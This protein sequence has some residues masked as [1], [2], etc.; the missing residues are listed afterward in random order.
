MK[1]HLNNLVRGKGKKSGFTLSE[2]VIASIIFMMVSVI[3]MT[4]FVNINRTQQKISLENAIY[5]DGRFMMERISRE[6]KQNTVDYE[7]YYNRLVLENSQ[8]G[9]QHGCYANNFYNPGSNGL[10]ALC[11]VPA[12]ADPKVTPGCVINKATLDYHTGKNPY[13]GQGTAED[14]ANAFCDDV[15]GASSCPATPELMANLQQQTELFLLSPDGS[16]KTF[17][18]RKLIQDLGGGN[19]EYALSLL[20]I[21]GADADLDGIIEQWY[22]VGPPRNFYCASGFECPDTYT[23]LDETLDGTV[24]ATRYEGFVPIS[25]L[26]T[27]IKDLRFYVSP[28]EDPTKAFAESDPVDAIQQQPHITV[29]LTLSPAESELKNYSGDVP[30]VTLQTTIS[31]RVYNEVKSYYARS[32]C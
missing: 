22:D 1:K 27:T 17:L 18:A 19:R 25:P 28:L 31:S 32:G 23:N 7:E 21:R 24:E 20:K 26:R 29:L 10:G 15:N 9:E 30:T 2:V 5:E 4:V 12:G 13:A 16:Q 11:S 6:I 3:G 14:R 8:Y